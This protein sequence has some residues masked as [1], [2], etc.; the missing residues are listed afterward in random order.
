MSK[1]IPNHT[2]A[3]LYVFTL[4][5]T[6]FKHTSEPV[7]AWNVADP[8]APMPI[9]VTG[10][11]L[12]HL[13]AHEEDVGEGVFVRCCRVTAVA[14]PTSGVYI[15]HQ[16]DSRLFIDLTETSIADTMRRVMVRAIDDLL[17]PLPF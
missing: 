2:G 11:T 1:Y 17:N 3:V 9:T 12:E 13:T 8:K 6:S 15:D 5:G 14:Y 7:I 4:Q 10:T 16:S